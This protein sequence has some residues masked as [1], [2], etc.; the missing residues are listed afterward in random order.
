MTETEKKLPINGLITLVISL[1]YLLIKLG[2]ALLNPT[3][4]GLI[5]LQV[6]QEFN[7]IEKSRAV[8]CRNG[9]GWEEPLAGGT[10]ADE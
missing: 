2:G 4:K 9:D 7:R 10:E 8:F 5:Y 1:F 3:I 6:A